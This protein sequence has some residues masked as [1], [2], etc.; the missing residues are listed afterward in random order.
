MSPS[1]NATL[2]VEAA[3]TC[4]STPTCKVLPW[5]TLRYGTLAVTKARLLDNLCFN[6]PYDSTT[7]V[8]TSR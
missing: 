4:P 3:S 2:G 8:G 5:P 1:N 6:L 7:C